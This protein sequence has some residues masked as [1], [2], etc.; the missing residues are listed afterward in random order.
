LEVVVPKSAILREF[1]SVVKP[2]FEKIK[3]NSVQVQILTDTRDT[4]LPRLMSGEIRV[5]I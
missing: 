4:L 3:S 2:L 5:K 1:N